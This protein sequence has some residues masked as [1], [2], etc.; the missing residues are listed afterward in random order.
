MHFIG[1]Y[2]MGLLGL[3]ILSWVRSRVDVKP[4]SQ[5]R[6]RLAMLL[7]E[8]MFVIGF[9]IMIG[10]GWEWFEF[11]V[12]TLATS[13]VQT[14]GVAQMGLADTMDDLFNDT[15]GALTAWI[16]WRSRI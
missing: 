16:L 4:R 14:Y 2:A 15:L 5:P 8:G 6:A 1:G 3:A 7:L 9:A 11:L 13:F 12:D 10:V